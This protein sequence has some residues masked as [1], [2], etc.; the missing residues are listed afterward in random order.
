MNAE[1]I[2]IG[3]ELLIGQIADTN[4]YLMCRHLS[5]NGFKINKITSL[6]DKSDTLVNAFQEA[7]KKADIVFI[8]GGLGPTKDDVTRDA[9]SRFFNTTWNISQD[10]LNRIK[11]FLEERGYSMND[12]NHDQAKVPDKAKVFIN[13][14]GTAPGLWLQKENTNFI[15]LPGVQFEMIRLLKKQIVPVLKERFIKNNFISKNINTQGIPEAYLSEKLKNW[16]EKLPDYLQVAYLPSPEFVKVRISGWQKDQNKLINDIEKAVEEI[17]EIIPG[18]FVSVGNESMEEILG[19]IL[20]EN[21]LTVSTAESCTGGFIASEITSVPGS[22][23]YFKGSV[24]AY[25]D[26]IKTKILNISP[27][28]IKSKGAVSEEVV[29]GM[30]NS[31]LHLYNTDYSIAVS[32]IAGPDGG[33]PQKPVGTTWIAVGRKEKI[34]TE[35]FLLGTIREVNIKKAAYKA[36]NML[37][38]LIIEDFEKK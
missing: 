19:N 34:I 3:D 7:T 2:T 24:V 12:S 4:S 17:R 20:S 11:E 30:V 29:R 36:M 15:F 16:Q 26:E 22:S 35:K 23:K 21:N 25:S 8:T 18:Y 1:I 32:G 9:I 33:T 37:R 14:I 31:L 27:D 28:I 10:V 13:Q 5:E 6:P 38:K